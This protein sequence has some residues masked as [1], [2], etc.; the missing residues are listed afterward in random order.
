M[1]G[2]FKMDFA[3]RPDERGSF[4]KSFQSS[5]F[6]ELG[7][8]SDFV[9]TFY[10]RSHANVIRGMHFQ[11]PPGDGA[12]LVYCLQGEI[13]DVA[14]DLR[15]DSA[16][17]GQYCTFTLSGEDPTAAYIPTGMAHGFCVLKGPALM[18]YHV[19]SEY[20]PSLDTGIR[21]DSFGFEWP[22]ASPVVSN[23][24]ASLPPLSDFESPFCLKRKSHAVN[25]T[26]ARRRSSRAG[27]AT[28]R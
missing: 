14:L 20:H 25:S 3:K 5:V 15:V 26:F 16:T 4:V 12:K 1:P 28:A 10:T 24:D 22:C 17:F 2:C 7:I 23:R 18:M 9:E 6:T 19:T 27:W 13:L 11:L 8:E 21:W